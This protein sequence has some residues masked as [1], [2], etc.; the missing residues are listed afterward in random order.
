MKARQ[1]SALKSLSV[2]FSR[3]TLTINKYRGTGTFSD[4]EMDELYAEEGIIR[5]A[6]ERYAI[7]ATGGEFF[8]TDEDSWEVYDN[9][10]QLI[11]NGCGNDIGEYSE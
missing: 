10:H 11:Y 2:A 5:E 3:V 6:L 9:R 7:L 8:T 1:F 4:A